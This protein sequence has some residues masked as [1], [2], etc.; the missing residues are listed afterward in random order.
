M[1]SLESYILNKKNIENLHQTPKTFGDYKSE[2]LIKAPVVVPDK[3]NQFATDRTIYGRL[4]RLLEIIKNNNGLTFSKL[5]EIISNNKFFLLKKGIDND[6]RYLSSQRLKNYLEFLRKVEWII[7]PEGKYKT[8][9]KGQK[10]CNREKW[11]R[12]LLNVIEHTVFPNELTMEFLDQ[13]I[14]ELL[15]DMIPATPIKIKERIGMKGILINLDL[16]TRVAL[17][18]LPTTGRFMKGSADAIFP[19]ERG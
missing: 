7:Q 6:D 8:T 12:S 17:Q 1:N 16:P 14:S 15:V 10:A 4:F 19:S 5:Q 2:L 9:E 11:N 13:I 3:F 18:V